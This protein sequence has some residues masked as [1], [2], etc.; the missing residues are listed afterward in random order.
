MGHESVEAAMS[1]L[2]SKVYAPSSEA[3]EAEPQAA[4][5][6]VM[7]DLLAGVDR[8]A[9]PFKGEDVHI[10]FPEGATPKDGPSA[11]VAIT[12]AL[13]S[14]LV[15]RPMRC[16]TAM[17]GEV[18]LRGHVL[19]VGG[20]RDKVLAARRAGLKHVLL[21]R[22]NKRHVEEEIVLKQVADMEL[23]YLRFIDEAWAFLFDPAEAPTFAPLPGPPPSRL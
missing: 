5:L 4:G 15:N 10:H 18:S 23:H 7:R 11:G 16:D 19:P 20:V 6:R 9:N 14:L 17:T 21:P 12:C 1:L 2:G 22:D 13:A 8:T 3:I